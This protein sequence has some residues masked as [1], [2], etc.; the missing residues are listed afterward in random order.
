MRGGGVAGG[1]GGA[2]LEVWRSGMG[3]GYVQFTWFAWWA[4]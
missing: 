1:G 2:Q 4:G 3:V